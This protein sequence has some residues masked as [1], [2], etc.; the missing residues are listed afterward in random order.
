MGPISVTTTS[1][2]RFIIPPCPH[3][4]I[5]P[6]G[7]EGQERPQWMGCLT[8]G[9]L[10]ALPPRRSA[11]GAPESDVVSSLTSEYGGDLLIN[12]NVILDL[13]DPCE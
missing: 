7:M 5:W 8:E 12:A 1:A 11:E 2:G 13:R 3:G 9:V 4:Q 6:E 10:S